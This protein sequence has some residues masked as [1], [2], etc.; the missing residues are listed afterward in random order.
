[1]SLLNIS[2]L[3]EA[4]TEKEIVQPNEIF[5]HVRQRLIENLSSEG[6]QDGMDGIL[7]CIEKN[8]AGQI[9]NLSYAGANNA[10]YGHL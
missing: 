5:N 9:T 4:I 10:P 2:F 3:N 6:R 8:N 7:V 1:M